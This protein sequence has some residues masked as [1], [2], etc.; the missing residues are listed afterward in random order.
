VNTVFLLSKG[1]LIAFAGLSPLRQANPIERR[2]WLSNIA[3]CRPDLTPVRGLIVGTSSRAV[4]D[5]DACE[6]RSAWNVTRGGSNASTVRHKSRERLS[7]ELRGAV[8]AGPG[9]SN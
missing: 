2:R 8:V 9:E 7:G 4:S 3:F 1:A 6:C 5:A